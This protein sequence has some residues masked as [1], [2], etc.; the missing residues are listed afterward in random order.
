MSKP[1]L[2]QLP[3][4]RM[5]PDGA[6]FHLDIA[7]LLKRHDMVWPG[8]PPAHWTLGAPIGNGD[9]GA[10]VYGHPDSLSFA[11][12]KTDVWEQMPWD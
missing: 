6:R 9:I 10:V 1:I 5:S 11:L 7:A 4:Q 3:Q 8:G 2:S 12:G